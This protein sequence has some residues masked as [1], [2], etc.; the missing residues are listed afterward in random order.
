MKQQERNITTAG[1]NN[2]KHFM[3]YSSYYVADTILNIATYNSFNHPHNLMKWVSTIN[4]SN[5]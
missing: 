5:L 1:T 2:W 4:S 3:E